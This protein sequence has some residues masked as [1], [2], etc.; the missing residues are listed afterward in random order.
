MLSG[1]PQPNPAPVELPP[2]V[3]L[4]EEDIREIMASG[5]TLRDVIREIES[6]LLSKSGNAS[7]SPRVTS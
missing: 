5:L 3:T 1:S 6:K 4:T 7:R 2:E